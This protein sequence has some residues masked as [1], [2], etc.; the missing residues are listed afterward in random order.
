MD[1]SGL[2]GL[3]NSFKRL[4]DESDE[5]TTENLSI[6]NDALVLLA[7]KESDSRSN[8]RLSLSDSER[9]QTNGKAT[10]KL[11]VTGNF[12]NSLVYMISHVVAV[13]NQSISTKYIWKRKYCQ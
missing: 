3:E 1:E 9:K 4:L 7:D 10:Q 11:M 12:L 13:T 8:E 5:E 6:F 2:D